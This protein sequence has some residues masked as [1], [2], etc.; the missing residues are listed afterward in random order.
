MFSLILTLNKSLVHTKV[1]C[2]SGDGHHAVCRALSHVSKG[3]LRW[4][5]SLLSPVCSQRIAGSSPFPSLIYPMTLV[6]GASGYGKEG[7]FGTEK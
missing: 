1:L 4:I 7:E 3:K 2:L 6:T 5:G